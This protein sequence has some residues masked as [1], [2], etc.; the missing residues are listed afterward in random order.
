M[1]FLKKLTPFTLPF[2]LAACGNDDYDTSDIEAPNVYEF[3][4]LTDPSA[5][6]SVDYRVPTTQLALIKELEYVISSY[7]LQGYGQTNGRD[8]VMDFLNRVY[9]GGTYTGVTNNLATVNLHDETSTPTLIK[10]IDIGDNTLTFADDSLAENTNIKNAVPADM[11]EQIQDWFYKI[12]TIAADDDFTTLY[13][14]NGFD[15]KALV[16][17]YLSVAMPY[18]QASNAFLNTSGLEASNVRSDS[19]ISYTQLEHNWDLAFGYFGTSESAKTQSLDAIIANNQ[20]NASDLN[21]YVFDVAAATAQRDLDSTLRESN[22]SQLIIDDFLDGRA[23]ISLNESHGLFSKRTT[24]VKNYAETILYNWEKA[25]AATLI[26]HIKNTIIKRYLATDYDH[27]WSM[28]T[29]YT[30]ALTMNPNSAL[31]PEVI[32]IL[33]KNKVDASDDRKQTTYLTTLFEAEQKIK[34]TYNFSESDVA[35][36]K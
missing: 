13:T 34:E 15:Y 30:Q 26:Y 35:S 19:S 16:I 10:G 17:G 31:A 29:V 25:L 23:T 36:W 20:N 28:M 6:S 32:T 24:L 11:H 18:Y 5:P 12:A 21:S 1:N 22:F 14:A 9:E 4:S 33:T 7:K 27:H 2:L 3:S 8:A